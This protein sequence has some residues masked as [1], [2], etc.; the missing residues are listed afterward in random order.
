[1]NRTLPNI[2]SLSRIV[3]SPVVYFMMISDKPGVVQLS[4][5][6]F[7]I[8]ALTDFFDGW[9]ARKFR[10]VTSLGTF[11]DPLADK[12]LTTAAFMGFVYLNIIPLWMV[13]IIIIRDFGT[14]ILR[15]VADRRGV[16][17]KTS[18][19]AKSKTFLQMVFISYLLALLFVKNMIISSSVRYIID[20]LINSKFVHYAM[21]LLTLLSFWTAIE[22]LIQNRRIFTANVSK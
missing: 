14:T 16:P 5:F 20:G 3:I 1:M 8:G 17:I 13:I 7:L 18:M 2:V 11:F 22:Y 21:F 19:S 15:L 4:C 9:L 6:L 10:L 12:F